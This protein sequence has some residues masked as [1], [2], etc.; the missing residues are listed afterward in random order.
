MRS[1]TGGY[2]AEGDEAEEVEVE[3]EE[4]EEAACD[5]DGAER[6]RSPNQGKP[7]EYA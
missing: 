2:T 3:E 4:E 5:E 7:S 1:R 6:G